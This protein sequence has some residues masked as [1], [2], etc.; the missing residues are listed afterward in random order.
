MHCIKRQSTNKERAIQE[1]VKNSF[2]YQH[3]VPLPPRHQCYAIRHWCSSVLYRATF[4]FTP[5]RVLGVSAKGTLPHLPQTSRSPQIPTKLR[6]SCSS[7]VCYWLGFTFCYLLT[8]TKRWQ[9]YWITPLMLFILVLAQTLCSI[10]ISY[11][12]ARCPLSYYWNIIWGLGFS[13]QKSHHAPCSQRAP[14][15]VIHFMP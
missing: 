10:I 5:L 7:M 15:T 8:Q 3:F 6:S 4:S 14:T 13:K 12:V 2:P 11:Q 9:K 1:G